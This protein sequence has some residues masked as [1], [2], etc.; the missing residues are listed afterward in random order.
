LILANILVD[1]WTIHK[2][3]KCQTVKSRTGQ[4]ID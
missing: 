1:N 4:L 3:I 2:Q